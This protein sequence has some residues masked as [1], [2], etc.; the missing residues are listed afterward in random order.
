MNIQCW[1]PLG[2]TGLISLQS[3]EASFRTQRENHVGNCY[4]PQAGAGTSSLRDPGHSGPGHPAYNS[5]LYHFPFV[6]SVLLVLFISSL[7]LCLHWSD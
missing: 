6:V 1:F 2:L 7:K 4:N 5:V 3:K